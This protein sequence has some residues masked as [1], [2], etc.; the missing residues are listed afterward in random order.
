MKLD[1]DETKAF[2]AFIK[3]KIQRTFLKHE[4]EVFAKGLKFLGVSFRKYISMQLEIIESDSSDMETL[5]ELNIINLPQNPLIKRLENKTKNISRNDEIIMNDFTVAQLSFTFIMLESLKTEVNKQIALNYAQHVLKSFNKLMIRFGGEKPPSY[6]IKFISNLKNEIKFL[7]EDLKEKKSLIDLNELI[8][9]KDKLH[10]LA[11]K[12]TYNTQNSLSK[13][14][15]KIHFEDFSGIEF[16]RLA[17]AY[18]LR[19]KQW[20]KTPEWLGQSGSDGGRDIWAVLNNQSYCYLCANYQKLTLTKAK[21]DIDKLVK[22]KTVPANLIIICGGV[23]SANLRAKIIKHAELIGVSTAKVITGVEFE[24]SIRSEAPELIKR[25]VEGQSF[26][27]SPEELIIL[28]RSC[29]ANTDREIV[30]LLAECFDRPAFTTPF[31]RE[32]SIPNFEKALDDTIEVLNTG[33]H[34]LRDGTIIRTIPSRHK[35]KN[36]NLKSQIDNIT[37]L[38]INLRDKFVDFKHKK[39]IQLCGCDEV[40]CAVF[41]MSDMACE[42][43][44]NIRASIFS[45]FKKIKPDSH[46][47]LN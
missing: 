39:E 16:E 21:S 30:D 28:N 29:T 33:V 13:T 34:R 40:D 8:A 24:E 9:Q 37:Q 19:M 1:E 4:K 32:S 2:T 45:E 23:V 26:P 5:P 15:H 31:Y 17:F 41:T 14:V 36:A 44:D 12:T 47:K 22:N 20:D 7:Q 3:E 42:V 38:V 46:L 11:S 18:I 43:L 25:F 10:S 6:L 27:D 35:I